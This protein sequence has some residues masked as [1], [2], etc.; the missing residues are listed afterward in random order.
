MVNMEVENY[1]IEQI[2]TDL[3]R[4]R[5]ELCDKQ[6]S[7]TTERNEEVCYNCSSSNIKG[8]DGERTCYNCGLVLS[9][10]CNFYSNAYDSE[11]VITY[12]KKK[13]YSKYGKIKQMEEWY[14]WTN[15]EKVV[16]KLTIY[17]EQFCK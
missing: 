14:K 1:T 16:Y 7:D 12:D 15:D 9:D 5:K 11:C 3:D 17:T 4:T 13:V 6:S 10:E 8:Y 2:W